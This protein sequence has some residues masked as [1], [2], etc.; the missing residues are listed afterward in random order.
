M[1]PAMASSQPRQLSYS[2]LKEAWRDHMLAL[3]GIRKVK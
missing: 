1:Y 2:E 3:A